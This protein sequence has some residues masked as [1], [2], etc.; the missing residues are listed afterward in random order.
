MPGGT[1]IVAPTPLAASA[2]ITA[3]RSVQA[4]AARLIAGVSQL[5][6]LGVVSA[7][8]RVLVT[9]K[10]GLAGAAITGRA[11][12]IP[13]AANAMLTT[14]RHRSFFISCQPSELPRNRLPSSL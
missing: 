4:P 9:V 3:A 7:T 10:V 5:P 14:A 13:G 2:D 12:G 1:M 6:S 11:A 8:S